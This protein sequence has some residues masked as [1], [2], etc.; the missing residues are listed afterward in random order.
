MSVFNVVGFHLDT[1]SLDG[2]DLSLTGNLYT[3][4]GD[5][6]AVRLPMRDRVLMPFQR[7]KWRAVRSVG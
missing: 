4:A 5:V 7:S 2:G 3:A 1:F 6:G